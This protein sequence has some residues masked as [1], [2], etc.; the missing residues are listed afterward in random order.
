MAGYNRTGNPFVDGAIIEANDFD[1]EFGNLDIAF[2]TSGHNHDGTDGNGP[3]ITTVGLADDAV[4]GAKIDSTTTITA[5]SFVGPLTGAVTGNVTGNLTGNV[6]GNLD[7]ASAT[8]DSLTITSGTAITSIDT[9]LSSV[10][11]SDDTLASAKAIKAYVDAQVD[12]ADQLTELT[13]VT[14]TTVADNEVLAYDT[15]SSKWINQTA[16]EAGLQ[17]N[18]AGLTSIAGLTTSANQM[19]Y[20]TGSDTYAT[21]SLTAAGRALLDDASASAQR[22]TLGLA[23][24]TNV[25]AYDAGLNSIAGLTTATD[26]MIY[27]TAADA[28]ATTSLTAAGR[29]LLDDNDASAQRTTLGLAIGTNVQAYNAGLADIAGLAKTDG[30]IIVGNGTNWVAESGSTARASLGLTIGTNVQ[31]YDAGLASISGLTTSANKMIYT[32]ASDTYSTTDL[33]AFGRSLIDDADAAAARTTLGLGT[34]ATTASTAY[35]TAAQGT[36]AD[37]ALPKAGGTMAG[38]ITFNSTQTFDGRDLSEDGT[39]LDGIETG[40]TA[41]QTAAEIR[42]LVESATDSNV[43]T[44]ADHT[45][46]DGIEVNATADQTAAE[47]RTLVG[48]ATDSNVFTDADHTKLDGIEASA[49]VTDT[50]NVTA[51]GALMDSEV[52]NLAQV[53]AFDSADYATAAQGTTADNALPKAGGTMTG[54]ITFNSSQTFDGRDLSVDGTKLDGIE[55]NATADQTAAEILTAIKTVDGAGSGLDADTLDGNQASAFLTGNQ[56]ITLSGDATGSGTT[57]ITVSLAANTVG[58][59]E[60][61]LSDGTAGQFLKTDGAGTISFATAPTQVTSFST[62]ELKVTY[63]N[64][65]TAGPELTLYHSTGTLSGGNDTAG[66]INFNETDGDS[67]EYNYGL[68][69]VLPLTGYSTARDGR[70]VLAVARNGYAAND[71]KS[72]NIPACAELDGVNETFTLKNMDLKF[73]S[74]GNGIDFS[75]TTDASGMTDELFDDYEE[76]TWTP[77]LTTTG[78]DFGSVTHNASRSGTYTKVGRMVTAHCYLTWNNITFGPASG[79]LAVGGLPYVKGTSMSQLGPAYSY[80]RVSSPFNNAT[81]AAVLNGNNK[82]VLYKNDQSNQY[83]VD[84]IT[85][86]TIDASATMK[87]LQMTVTYEV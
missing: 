7:A 64:E 75:A 54:D 48:S 31:A 18:D 50:D 51:A 49:D 63:V 20:T 14:I 74:S 76:G 4:T 73:F 68:I 16:V 11:A 67:T 17:P 2:G 5:A 80:L 32:T 33:S 21:T 46:L 3:K 66:Q 78:S 84:A 62:D 29:A 25:Q 34:A 70:M 22:T 15:T 72:S 53:K 9:D 47:I 1:I 10:S 86:N 12:T 56:T 40:A 82:A 81:L 41:D 55:V 30:N 61:N 52:T 44:D 39:K 69:E 6:V 35:A 58:V 43:F 23:I 8:I 60:L 13:D 77:I 65:G 87:Y 45:K 27:T 37:N 59:N 19:I 24:G 79:E 38:N 71:Y 57:A 83:G 36:K 28:Y 42:S 26:K 85:P